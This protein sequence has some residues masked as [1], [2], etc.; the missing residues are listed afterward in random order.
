MVTTRGFGPRV[1]GSSPGR[2]SLVAVY[3]SNVLQD[4]K[5][6]ELTNGKRSKRVRL[7][8]L[9]AGLLPVRVRSFR[10]THQPRSSSYNEDCNC[11]YVGTEQGNYL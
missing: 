9:D 1:P 10:L 2:A 7:P 5:K 4:N 3:I 6:S 8:A 11:P